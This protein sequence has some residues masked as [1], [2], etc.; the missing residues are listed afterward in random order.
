MAKRTDTSPAEARRLPP[1]VTILLTGAALGLAWGSVMWMIFEL[2]GRD[3]GARG[4][5]YVAITTR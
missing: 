5:A 3:S 4:W 1:R 2:A